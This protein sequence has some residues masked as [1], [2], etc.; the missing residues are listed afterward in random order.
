MRPCLGTV[1]SKTVIFTKSL[2]TV[3]KSLVS[4]IRVYE[5]LILSFSL[6]GVSQCTI[7]PPGVQ[8]MTT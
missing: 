2:D 3:L 1:S 6:L 4:V 7:A 8:A 5:R